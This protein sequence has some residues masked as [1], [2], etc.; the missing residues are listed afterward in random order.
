MPWNPEPCLD[1]STPESE[2][3]ETEI[4]R[5][6][7]L[8][9]QS[10]RSSRGVETALRRGQPFGEPKSET[11]PEEVQGPAACR[12]WQSLTLSSN[13]PSSDKFRPLRLWSS[14]VCDRTDTC[15]TLY[16]AISTNKLCSPRPDKGLTGS[17]MCIHPNRLK[18]SKSSSPDVVDHEWIIGGI[19]PP[20]GLGWSG[21]CNPG[22]RTLRLG[23][24]A[25][26]A[27]YIYTE[28][29]LYPSWMSLARSFDQHAE[30]FNNRF[31]VP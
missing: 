6:V 27:Q 16:E 11:W 18:T 21:Y 25:Y 28:R 29:A 3:R 8:K 30:V 15:S 31:T 12:M 17:A 23:A 26:A 13:S 19:E 10:L 2:R 9:K 1:S 14:A 7:R 24:Y 5:R 4:E 22:G 20:S